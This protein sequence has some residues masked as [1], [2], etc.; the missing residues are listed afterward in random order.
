MIDVV[1][2]GLS[3]VDVSSQGH[4]L[5]SPTLIIAID[6]PHITAPVEELTSWV[7]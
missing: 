5:S 6:S 4:H 7:L 3:T 2:E 1:S